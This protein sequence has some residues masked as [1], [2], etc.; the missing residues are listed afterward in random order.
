MDVMEQL[1]KLEWSGFR[2]GPGFGPMDSGPGTKYP[3]C[4]ECGG[5]KDGITSAFRATAHGHRANCELGATVSGDVDRLASVTAIKQAIETEKLR[6]ASLK[7][8]RERLKQQ[9]S[10]LWQGI[11]SAHERIRDLESGATAP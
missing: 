3:A 7:E 5:I 9:D 2:E 10:V 1:K 8:G 6:I 11:S 4:P